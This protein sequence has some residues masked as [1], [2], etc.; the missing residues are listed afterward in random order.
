VHWVPTPLLGGSSGLA[1]SQLAP[2]SELSFLEPYLLCFSA[3]LVDPIC[4]CPDLKFSLLVL[5]P[6]CS[7]C[8]VIPSN[9]LDPNTYAA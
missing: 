8:S 6:S 4:L 2:A 9:I 1:W 5:P 7:L 3:C